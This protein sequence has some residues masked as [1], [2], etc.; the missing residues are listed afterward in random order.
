MKLLKSIISG[1]VDFLM[2]I[3]IL[4]AIGVSLVSLTSDN[5]GVSKIGKYMPLS[6]QTNSM[7]DTILKGDFIIMEECD[8]SKLQKGDI[9]AFFATE[10]DQVIIKTHRIV[11][12]TEGA[13]GRSFITRGD[14][15]G[16]I[17][18]IKKPICELTKSNILPT[19]AILVPF[20]LPIISLGNTG[21]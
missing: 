9:I 11:E 19:C 7:E 13:G 10:Q 1:I 18:H 21:T 3:V 17:I 16:R 8:V 15:N 4:I 14:N 20:H 2:L 12:I 6:V 5:N